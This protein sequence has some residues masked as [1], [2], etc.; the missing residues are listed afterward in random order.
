MID[1]VMVQELSAFFMLGEVKTRPFLMLFSHFITLS[2]ELN[3][4][5]FEVVGLF[6]IYF[7]H[8]FFF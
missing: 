2:Q 3:P 1:G 6:F 4:V 5:I 7:Y 8:G